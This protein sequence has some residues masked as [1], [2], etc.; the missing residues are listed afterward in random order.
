MRFDLNIMTNK[1]LAKKRD[2]KYVSCGW[3]CATEILLLHAH[4]N[5]I[6]SLLGP[7]H[8]KAMPSRNLAFRQVKMISLLW[9][10]VYSV[11]APISLAKSD[12]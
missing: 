9:H 8:I 12:D 6:A 4:N 5:G 1:R 7:N 3:A 2:V 10:S 11:D